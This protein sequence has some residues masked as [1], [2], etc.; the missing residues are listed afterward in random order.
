MLLEEESQRRPTIREIL[1]QSDLSKLF[2][3][4]AAAEAAAAEAAAVAEEEEE[5]EE[6]E[7]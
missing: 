5:E 3:K 2:D 6:E 7:G 4:E 1:A